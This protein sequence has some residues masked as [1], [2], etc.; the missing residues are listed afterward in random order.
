[1][2]A[3]TVLITTKHHTILIDTI[4]QL[5]LEYII[6]EQFN[7]STTTFDYNAILAVITSNSYFMSKA[8]I[9]LFPNLMFIGRLGS[10][11]EII[12]VPYANSKGITCFSSP[13]GNANAVAEHALGMLLN[14]LNR[15]N[16][17]HDEMKQGLFLRRPNMG[18]ELSDIR[19]GII[20]YG[21]NGKRFAEILSFL[22]AS[23]Y[24]YDIDPLQYDGHTGITFCDTIEALYANINA[25]SFHIPI[26]KVTP[27]FYDNAIDQ[28][29]APFI[30]INCARGQLLSSA[31]IAAGLASG[32]IIGACIDVWESEPINR[33]SGA[34][35]SAANYILNHPNVIATPHIAGYTHQAFY[36]MSKI[37]ADA[38]GKFIKH[39]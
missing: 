15:I 12:D 39:Q 18:R 31:A 33:L 16:Y 3:N 26:S 2:K 5:G 13:A 22:G 34:A 14:L 6:D 35:L 23:V 30:L 29:V 27:F 24:V 1:M 37:I 10:G 25:L 11:M 7:G 28:I 21:N 8:E 19:M 9:D 32:K 4:E 20:G 38:L 17:A 36:K